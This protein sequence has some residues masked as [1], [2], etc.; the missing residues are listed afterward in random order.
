MAD[1]EEYPLDLYIF[2]KWKDASESDRWK[3]SWSIWD[4]IM[5][6]VFHERAKIEDLECPVC[7]KQDLYTCL[8]AYRLLVKSPEMTN[9]VY[10]GDRFV[11]CHSCVVQ[12]R[13]YGE[14]PEWTKEKD[15]IWVSERAKNDAMEQ[16]PD[17]F[18]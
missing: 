10:I 2:R 17:N 18:P 12:K 3:W 15:V 14:F 8:L 4:P 13:D 5:E 6:S 16:F 9:I 1:K 11:G 7:G